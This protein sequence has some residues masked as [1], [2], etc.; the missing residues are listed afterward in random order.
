MNCTV[1][2]THTHT[3][4]LRYMCDIGVVDKRKQEIKGQH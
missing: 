4:G 3:D 2:C 1:Q